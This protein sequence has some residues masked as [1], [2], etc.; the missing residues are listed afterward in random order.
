MKIKIDKDMV[1]FAPENE[2]ETVM[3]ETFWKL[4]V[5]C[6]RFNK[7]LVPVGEYTPQ[8]QNPARFIVEG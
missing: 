5:D 7:K 2:D 3:T 6:V 8:K 1:Q 4:M